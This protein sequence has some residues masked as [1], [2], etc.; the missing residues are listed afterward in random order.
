MNILH[1]RRWTSGDYEYL[2]TT[3]QLWKRPLLG[4]TWRTS[5]RHNP[6]DKHPIAVVRVDGDGLA[7]A[8]GFGV[9]NDPCIVVAA[10]PDYGGHPTDHWDDLAHTLAEDY[11]VERAAY[12]LAKEGV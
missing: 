9:P 4:G 8:E 3:C 10:W 5:V 1:G 7:L 6:L 12:A 2:H 11:A